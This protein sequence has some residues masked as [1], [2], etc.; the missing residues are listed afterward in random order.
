M[1][2]KEEQLGKNPSQNILYMIVEICQSKRGFIMK[3]IRQKLSV[4]FLPIIAIVLLV[5]GC[6]EAKQTYIAG[7]G[8]S[9]EVPKTF[10]KTE[11]DGMMRFTLPEKNGF[12]LHAKSGADGADFDI[13]SD[14]EINKILKSYETLPFDSQ[15][16]KVEIKNIN[17]DL[18]GVFIAYTTTPE[19][20]SLLK[21][22]SEDFWFIT[23][24]GTG[25]I[26]C[27]A[28]EKDKDFVTKTF[29]DTLKTIT[30]L[31]G[32]SSTL[33]WKDFEK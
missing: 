10:V 25:L 3:G 26:S 16:E 29:E 6:G 11:E 32:T 15:P 23:P 24:E 19:P 31:E 30:L 5:S 9:F 1:A 28:L 17:K 20:Q 27:M 4:L 18:K 22:Y 33:T 8:F 12:F 14:A 2:Q 13:T 21:M 7:N